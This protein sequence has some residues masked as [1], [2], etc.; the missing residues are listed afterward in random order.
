MKK[1]V[2]RVSEEELQL[3]MHYINSRYEEGLLS[4]DVQLQL[5]I[6]AR[7]IKRECEKRGCLI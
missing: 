4:A 1:W 2:E 7:E 3:V 5:E 6:W